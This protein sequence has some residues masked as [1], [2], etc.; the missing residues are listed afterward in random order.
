MASGDDQ[1]LPLVL[2]P[3]AARIHCIDAGK[4]PDSIVPT[5]VRRKLTNTDPAHPCAA[6]GISAVRSTV[7]SEESDVI[8]PRTFPPYRSSDGGRNFKTIFR[9][10]P[11]GDDYHL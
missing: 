10:A 2:E 8:Y 6:R 4:V 9:G 5:M 7:G 3:G 11:G 1:E